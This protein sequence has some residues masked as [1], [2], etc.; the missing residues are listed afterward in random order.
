MSNC[1]THAQLKRWV[2]KKHVHADTSLIMTR[3]L[4]L[5]SFILANACNGIFPGMCY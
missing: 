2:L 4:P 1:C 3:L 5:S